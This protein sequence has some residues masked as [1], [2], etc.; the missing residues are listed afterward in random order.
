MDLRKYKRVAMELK[1]C[2]QRAMTLADE[3]DLF[4]VML[5]ALKMREAAEGLEELVRYLERK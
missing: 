1:Q 3:K 5:Y 4:D 2:S